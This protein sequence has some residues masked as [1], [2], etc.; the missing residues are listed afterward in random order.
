MSRS[1]ISPLARKLWEFEDKLFDWRYNIRAAGD[2]SAW[3]RSLRT[4]ISHAMLEHPQPKWFVDLGFGTGKA[5]LY[6]YK[7][8]LF[9][10]VIGIDY[11][12]SRLQAYHRHI[13]YH[14]VDAR[15]YILRGST[16]RLL[17]MFNPFDGVVL[18]E[19]LINNAET[20][21]NTASIVA[22]AN[23][24]HRDILSLAG[25]ACIFR[26]SPYKLSLWKFP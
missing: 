23:D 15:D 12:I 1:H 26:D 9:S 11:N 25:M 4:L 18:S 22:Y 3:C 2:H 13:L 6:A 14:H 10:Q 24:I 21:R 17:F 19:F 7:T 5:C 8:R 20:I 16:S